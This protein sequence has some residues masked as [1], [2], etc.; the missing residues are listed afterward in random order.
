MKRVALVCLL[1]PLAAT[2]FS[3][4]AEGGGVQWS[5]TLSMN[6]INNLLTSTASADT[7]DGLSYLQLNPSLKE[8]PYGFD[9]E[10]AVGPGSSVNLRYAYGYA[11]FLNGRV[12]VSVGKWVDPDTFALNSF[13]VGGSD[14]PGSFGNPSLVNAAGATGNGINGIELKLS[15]MK[16]LVL[17]YVLPYNND[18]TFDTS[19]TRS[20][21]DASYTREKVVQ[22]VLG[23]SL[24][25]TGVADLATPVIIMNHNKLYTTANILVS[26]SLVAGARY[27]LDHDVSTRRVISN[28][29]YFTLGGKLGDFSIGGDVGLYFPAGGSAGFEILGTTSYTLKSI[30]PT[31]DLEPYM[32]VS[33]VSGAYQ[34]SQYSSI[35]FN[36]QLRLLLGKGQH[37]LAGGYTVTYDL[38]HRQVVVSQLNILMQVYF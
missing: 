9:S 1:M 4:A 34:E 8:G 38:D 32:T 29:A 6:L 20:T 7:V 33:Y 2:V 18:D 3:Q 23:Y 17:G 36:P 26:E 31:V 14:G 27:E 21:L 22:V 12:H 19:L 28:N 5:G 13:F 10:L 24:S 25:H 35:N 11:D 16:N 15:P 30:L 37:E